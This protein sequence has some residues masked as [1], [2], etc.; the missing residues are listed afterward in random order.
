MQ[1]TR[2]R[3]NLYWSV[4]L[5]GL[6]LVLLGAACVQPAR[7][8][9]QPPVEKVLSKPEITALMPSVTASPSPTATVTSTHTPSPTTTQTPTMPPTTTPLPT[10]VVLRG[11]VLER[12]NCRYG[13]GAPYLYK[14]GLVPGSNLEIIGRNDRGTWVLVQAIGGDNPCWVKASLM[15]LQGEVMNVA[16]TYLP[17]P[18]SPY[19]HPPYGVQA[20][21]Q[22]DQVTI[23]WTWIRLRAGDETA[24]SPYLIEAWLCQDGELVFTPIGPTGPEVMLT[25]QAGCADPSHGRIALA[26]KHG[27]SQ[28]S[29]IPWPE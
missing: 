27:Y 24:E 22:G 3:L 9:P 28:W 19:Y 18:P 29:E 14:Y 25:D 13:P 15:E 21:R 4:I 17:L 16:P 12:A 11:E 6:A 26:E 10:Y 2:T 5:I 7:I 20:E 23:R 8:T 1:K